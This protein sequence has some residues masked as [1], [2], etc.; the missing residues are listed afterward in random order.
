VTVTDAPKILLPILY[1]VNTVMAVTLQVR[2]SRG[3]ETPFGAGVALR[4]S[5]TAIAVASL[6]LA[7]AA[8]TT[9]VSTIAVLVAGTALLTVG[10]LTQ[11]A[12]AWGITATLTPDDRRGEYTGTFKLG[13]QVQQA[14][15]PAGLTVLAVSTHGWGWLVIAALMLCAGAY[16]PRLVERVAVRYASRQVTVPAQPEPAAVR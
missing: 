2:A 8:L 6:F 1:A 9:G 10:E 7:A 3:S 16:A 14:L 12:G 4:R 11:S 15:G 13:G 5:G